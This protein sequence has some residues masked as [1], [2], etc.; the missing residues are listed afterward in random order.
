LLVTSARVV[1]LGGQDFGSA[2]PPSERHDA[3]QWILLK[4]SGAVNNSLVLP[5]L[6]FLA[7][8]CV[9]TLGTIRI[10][11]LSRG[12]KKL[13]TLLGFF[14][15]SMWLFAIGQ[16][17]SHLDDPWCFFAFAGGFASGNYLGVVIHEK[18]ALGNS[19]VQI[20]THKD[21]GELARRLTE[22]DFGVTRL[23]G[24]G[25]NG[26]VQVVF[27][28]VKRREVEKITRLINNFDP[29]AFYAIDEVQSVNQGIF[30]LEKMSAD[31]NPLR[32]LFRKIG[33]TADRREKMGI[34]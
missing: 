28:I 5:M 32:I 2:K 22:A 13:A 23:E 17:M 4:R 30:P 12:Q 24:H 18:L 19:V 31:A 9:V 29:M 11:F 16:I 25:A 1:F 27:S 15:V 26:P 33:I 21:A 7:E 3:I 14:E 20:I 10:I 34:S 6:V 8:M